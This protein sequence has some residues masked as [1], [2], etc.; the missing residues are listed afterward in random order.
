MPRVPSLSAA[1]TVLA[2][3]LTAVGC[4][5]GGTYVIDEVRTLDAPRAAI[6]A[7]ADA[8]ARLLPA[9]PASAFTRFES[10]P[11]GDPRSAATGAA[12]FSWTIPDGWEVGPERQMR[13][14]TLVPSGK[15][16]IECAVSVLGGNGGGF[17][18]NVNRW[19]QQVA[20]EPATEAELAACA[21]LD[22]LG[23][24]ARI[25]EVLEGPRGVLGLVC[26][27]GAQTLFVKLTGP[28]EAL[29]GERER[30]LAFCR[31]IR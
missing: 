31:S 16:G 10:M 7:A 5:G 13:L 29:R 11:K 4:D 14:V 8:R 1:A 24:K 15:P 12:G 6:P 21:T 27:T 25:V 26:E 30:F 20:L 17:A 23:V 19:R 22:V 18:A 3:V 2:T 9:G 28:S